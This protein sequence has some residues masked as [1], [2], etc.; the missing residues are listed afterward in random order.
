[1]KFDKALHIAIEAAYDSTMHYRMGA[2]LYDKSNYVTGFNRAFDCCVLARDK[3]YSMHSE[4]MAVYKGL[5]TGIKFEDSTLIVVRINSKNKLR[6]SKPCNVCARIINRVG[7]K[8]IYYVNREN[9]IVKASED[10][11]RDED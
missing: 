8:D 7:I 10:E 1:M 6:Y 5:R 4:E 9:Q 11:N 3:Q 2:V